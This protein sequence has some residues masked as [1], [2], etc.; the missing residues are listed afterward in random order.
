MRVAT[1]YK[2]AGGVGTSTKQEPSLRILHPLDWLD[3]TLPAGRSCAQLK[4][5]LEEEGE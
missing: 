2:K 3:P 5:L 1:Q 4:G